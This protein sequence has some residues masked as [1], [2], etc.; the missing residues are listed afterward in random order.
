MTPPDELPTTVSRVFDAALRARPDAEALVARSGRWSYTQLDEAC[1]RAAGA[2]RDL[3]VRPGDRVA[4]SLDNDLG[5]L[6]AFHGTMRLGAIWVGV[7]QALAPPEQSFLLADSATSLILSDTAPAALDTDARVIGSDEWDAAAT[8]AEPARDL[9]PVDP[10]AAAALTYTSGT[11]GRPKGAIHSQRNLLLP[12][13]VLVDTRGWDHTLRKGDSLPLTIVNMQALT[14][15]LTAQAGGTCVII[16][17]MWADAVSEWI[18]R[19][20]VTVWNGPPALLHSLITSDAVRSTALASLEEV[21]SG[22]SALPESLR[23]RFHERFGKPLIGTYGLSEAP[24]VVSIDPPG[25]AHVEGASGQV[26]PH[27][28]VTLAD[29]Q[30]GLGELCLSPATDGPYAGLYTP[31]L[32][33][34]GRPEAS[35]AVLAGGVVHTG[36]VGFVDDDGWLHVRDRKNL[37]I[38]RGGA[39]VYPAEVERVLH[40]ID[41]V[42]GAAVTGIADERLGQR[43]VAA[44]ETDEGVQLDPESIRERCGTELARYKVPD[45]IEVVAALPRNAMG[46]VDRTALASLF[47]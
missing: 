37:V 40:T 41:G 7:N 15:L 46:K 14:S 24:T 42:A 32:G 39:N 5:I 1:A 16:D 10:D 12:G 17:T 22:G 34:W 2:L 45:R 18:E 28:D 9:P 23:D 30:D 47:G 20:A 4:G 21:W 44:V 6:V 11:T 43:V 29:E 36:D 38:I 19:E 3:G 31:L 8:A 26:L 13:R 27:L 33:Y 35:E 25:G